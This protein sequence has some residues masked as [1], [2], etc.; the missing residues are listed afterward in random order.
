ML[1][2]FDK[3]NKATQ[4]KM[5]RKPQTGRKYIHTTKNFC[6]EYKKNL[7][8]SMITR[9]TTQYKYLNKQFT[10]EDIEK[11]NKHMEISQYY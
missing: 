5:K 3:E 9:Q 11:V 10:K 7:Y 6:R 1:N 8:H 4:Q 2:D